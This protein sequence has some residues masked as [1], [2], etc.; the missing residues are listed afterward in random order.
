[1]FVAMLFLIALFLI[2]AKITDNFSTIGDGTTATNKSFCVDQG[3]DQGNRPCVRWNA[4][5]NNWEFSDSGASGSY[6]A[7]SGLGAGSVD[8]ITADTTLTSAGSYAVDAT[9]NDVTVTLPP[10]ANVQE[11][12][13]NIFRIDG[14]DNEVIIST[15]AMETIFGAT[16]S[17]HL[18][19]KNDYL[20][21][22]SRTSQWDI[23]DRKIDFQFHISDSQTA[24][25]SSSARINNSFN[26]TSILTYM[27]F[28]IGLSITGKPYNLNF[29]RLACRTP[30]LSNNERLSDA[31][32]F[33]SFSPSSDNL[34]SCSGIGRYTFGSFY[35]KKVEISGTYEYCFF[36]HINRSS[37]ATQ[38]NIILTLV[39]NPLIQNGNYVISRIS[40]PNSLLLRTPYNS[41]ANSYFVGRRCI[42]YEFPESEDPIFFIQTQQSQI[43]MSLGFDGFAGHSF[44]LIN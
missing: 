27:V 2:G 43:Q 13:V 7:F 3:N 9:S 33:S 24:T 20:N 4:T 26:P 23:L 44:R 25:S 42:K 32:S 39:L 29:I 21:L 6:T 19:E 22:R 36:Y 37:S 8:L 18:W 31:L 38:N 30:F 10:V 16:R 40:F 17:I 41:S 12:A 5:N 28:N 11:Q 14:S 1:M 15:N 35:L 34:T